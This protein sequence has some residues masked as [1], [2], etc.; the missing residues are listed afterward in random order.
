MT[1]IVVV[2]TCAPDDLRRDLRQLIQKVNAIMATLADVQAAVAN[3]N[4]VEASVVA[5]LQTLS[6]ALKAAIASNDPAALQAVVDSINA[7]STAMAAA[8]AANTPAAPTPPTT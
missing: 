2:D 4:T 1:Q 7:D 6:D 8:V 5:M 3:L